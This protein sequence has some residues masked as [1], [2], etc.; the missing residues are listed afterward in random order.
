[1]TGEVE[2]SGPDPCREMGV[3]LIALAIKFG[4]SFIVEQEWI[5]I[6]LRTHGNL[7]VSGR[8]DGDVL[9]EVESIGGAIS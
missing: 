6:A 1:L 3:L 4:G 9:V 2:L 8:E 5:D 7:S